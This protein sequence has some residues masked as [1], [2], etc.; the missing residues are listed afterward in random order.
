MLLRMSTPGALENPQLAPFL[1]VSALAR[2]ISDKP[3]A[4][5][6]GGENR[7][8]YALTLYARLP[9][10]DLIQDATSTRAGVTGFNMHHALPLAIVL[11]IGLYA[12]AN[13]F[14]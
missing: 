7:H 6:M 3:V 4:R 8:L 14:F 2:R 13:L 11:L 5:L 12:L 9:V 10:A 1:G